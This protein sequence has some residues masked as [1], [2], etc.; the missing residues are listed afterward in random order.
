MRSLER[1]QGQFFTSAM[2][3]NAHLFEESGTS[4][5]YVYCY[6]NA[7]QRTVGLKLE[8]IESLLKKTSLP[9]F[10]LS[11]DQSIKKLTVPLN[12]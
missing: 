5:Q 4:E 3:V 6:L 10:P 9:T 1:A 2:A 12:S 7:L 8:F 11:F